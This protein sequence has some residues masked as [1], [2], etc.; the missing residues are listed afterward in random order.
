M[1]NSDF[2][3]NKFEHFNAD[4]P[5]EVWDNVAAELDK[6]KKRRFAI[7]WFSGI[8]AFLVVG[9]FVGYFYRASQNP[10]SFDAKS[11]NEA[12]MH[13]VTDSLRK[14]NSSSTNAVCIADTAQENA[15][16]MNDNSL[17]QP[18]NK[19]KRNTINVAQAGYYK[20]DDF[21]FQEFVY[22]ELVPIHA[23]Y[24]VE[25]PENTDVAVSQMDPSTT[26]EENPPIE[27]VSLPIVPSTEDNEFKPKKWELALFGGFSLTQRQES[28]GFLTSGLANSPN[29]EFDANNADYL[30]LNDPSID[31]TSPIIRFALFKAGLSINRELAPRWRLESGLHYLRYGVFYENTQVWSREA[32]MIQVPIFAHFSILQSKNIDWRIGSGVGMGYVFRQP[33]LVFRSEWVNSTTVMF[34]LNPSWSV[35]VQPEARM[36]FYDSRIPQVGKLSQ[37]YW[38]GNLG[39]VRRF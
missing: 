13:I 3:K 9:L 28:Y 30:N 31:P 22:E 23:P 36:V 35:F 29:L 26:S 19:R 33:S 37:W 39:V 20:N 24:Q 27:S 4:V 18:Q 5:T 17:V 6:K 16:V 21:D 11:N 1:Q 32:Q 14:H 2:L 7:W 15:N 34:Q 8:A 12:A 10:I 25:D 38:G